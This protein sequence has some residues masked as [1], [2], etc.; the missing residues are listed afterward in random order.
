MLLRTE[1]Y[2]ILGN[3]E[4]AILSFSQI[5][6]DQLGFEVNEECKQDVDAG[7]LIECLCLVSH[8]GICPFGD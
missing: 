2:L 8:N 4:E 1:N 3:M 6:F 5:D 7:T